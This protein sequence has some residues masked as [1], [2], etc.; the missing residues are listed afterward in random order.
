LCRSTTCCRSCVTAL[1]C[2]FTDTI[3]DTRAQQRRC[4]CIGRSEKNQINDP[5]VPHRAHHAQASIGLSECCCLALAAC[6]ASR[7]LWCYADLIFCS[8]M[9]QHIVYAG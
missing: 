5:D 6:L 4:G 3:D 1:T 2:L 8:K 9:I 7:M